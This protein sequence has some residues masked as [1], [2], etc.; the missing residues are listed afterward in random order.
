MGQ[1]IVRITGEL[2]A[3]IMTEGWKVPSAQGEL[4]MCNKGLPPDA[5]LVG[6]W[7][8]AACNVAVLK[9]ESASWSEV[10]PGNQVPRVEVCHSFLRLDQ[11]GG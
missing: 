7:W 5:K 3:N 1:R 2:L 10:P 4:L 9:F 11:Q 8:D 6:C